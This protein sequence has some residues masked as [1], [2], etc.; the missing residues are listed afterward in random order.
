M[1]QAFLII[2]SRL[3][4]SIARV[5][6]LLRSVAH[7]AYFILDLCLFSCL[8]VFLR[9]LQPSTI[10]QFVLADVSCALIPL[11]MVNNQDPKI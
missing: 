9:C 5:L 8:G 11:P 6:H 1:T 10:I 7:W 4:I 3:D 2:M